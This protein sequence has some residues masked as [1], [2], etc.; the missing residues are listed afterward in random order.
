MQSLRITNKLLKRIPKQI[1]STNIKKNVEKKI[2]NP[3]NVSTLQCLNFHSSN[4]KLNIDN[5]LPFIDYPPCETKIGELAPTFNNSPGYFLFDFFFFFL[6]YILL[7]ML[8][9]FYIKII[10]YII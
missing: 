7:Y 6:N 8:Y 2:I 1:L 5:Y 4:K 10:N 9:S 3:V